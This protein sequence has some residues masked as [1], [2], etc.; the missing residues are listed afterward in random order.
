MRKKKKI[1]VVKRERDK[2]TGI[3][4]RN[5]TQEKWNTTYSKASLQNFQPG[6]YH[7][8]LFI[9]DAFNIILYKIYPVNSLFYHPKSIYPIRPSLNL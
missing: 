6:E 1:I 2:E 8:K 9:P 7:R 4:F 5:R 3:E